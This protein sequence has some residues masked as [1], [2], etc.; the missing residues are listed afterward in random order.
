ML[1]RIELAITC[2]IIRVQSP[3]SQYTQ[4]TQDAGEIG[5][6][7]AHIGGTASI[8]NLIHDST[9]AYIDFMVVNIERK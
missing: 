3:P 9:H 1:R 6:E 7:Y 5:T 8:N 2:E 4:N